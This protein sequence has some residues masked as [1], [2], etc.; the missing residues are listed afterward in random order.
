MQWKES[1]GHG[2]LIWS[3]EHQLWWKA[4]NRGYTK[5]IHEAGVYGFHESL[6]I[7]GQANKHAPRDEW[8]H[9]VMVQAIF[10]VSDE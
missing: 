7:V 2:Y 5:D 6:E 1:V 10:P 3:N 9:E 4:N 8:P